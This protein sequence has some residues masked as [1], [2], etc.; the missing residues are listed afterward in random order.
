[1]SYDVYSCIVGVRLV[2]L[3]HCP[4]RLSSSA[5]R[6]PWTPPGRTPVAF[7]GIPPDPLQLDVAI[8]VLE[9]EYIAPTRN[10]WHYYDY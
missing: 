1:M 8:P 7:G 10:G 5:P 6:D 2:R 9:Y 3:L 4:G